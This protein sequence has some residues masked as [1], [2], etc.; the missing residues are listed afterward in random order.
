MF[1]IVF[2]IPVLCSLAALSQADNAESQAQF[3]FA[4]ENHFDDTGPGAKQK[5]FAHKTYSNYEDALISY[6]SDKDTKLPE[7][8]KVRAYKK[9]VREE[10]HASPKHIHQ[11]QIFQN[12]PKISTIPHPFLQPRFPAHRPEEVT[13]F[14]HSSI[15]HKPA[16]TGSLLNSLKLDLPK[17]QPLPK[18]EI[19]K[20]I[21]HNPHILQSPLQRPEISQLPQRLDLPLTKQ[22]YPELPQITKQEFPLLLDLGGA[23]GMGLHVAKEKGYDLK[24]VNP[25]KVRP[26]SLGHFTKGAGYEAPVFH[27]IL[28]QKPEYEYAYGVH[29]SIV[30]FWVATAL[31]LSSWRY[32]T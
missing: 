11:S 21:P 6:A 26:L 9:L 25:I 24:I 27:S 18:L 16:D 28:R 14:Q 7:A 31:F 22:I 30:Y 32:R 15:L 1:V 10:H 13:D 5:E 29:V 17:L 12:Y 4:V 2:Q 8:D 3:R 20:L 23:D 19:P